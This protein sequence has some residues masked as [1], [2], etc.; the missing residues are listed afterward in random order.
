MLLALPAAVVA[1]APTASSAL[2][3]TGVLVPPMRVIRD[4]VV[5]PNG[6]GEGCHGSGC[7][8]SN[9]NSGKATFRISVATATAVTIE[10]EIRTPNGNDDSFFT[11]FDNNAPQLWHTGIYSYF[12]WRAVR[13]CDVHYHCTPGARSVTLTAGVHEFHVGAREDGAE[14][15]ALRI[16]SGDAIFVDDILG[17]CTDPN[18]WQGNP[19][20]L[21]LTSTAGLSFVDDTPI[22]EP[23]R[24]S[25]SGNRLVSPGL[26]QTSNA[27]G[28]YDGD[29]ALSGCHA[30]YDPQPY[31]DFLAQVTVASNDDDA[32]GFTFGWQSPI[33]HHV[34]FLINDG[35]PYRSY[36]GI[37]GPMIK[38]KRRNQHPCMPT[39][40]RSYSCW[41]PPYAYLRASGAAVAAPVSSSC[42]QTGMDFGNDETCGYATVLE[43]IDNSTSYVPATGYFS[44]P[45]RD[46][47]SLRTAAGC[48][49][50]CFTSR[51]GCD[52]FSFEVEQPQGAPV[53]ICYLKR[54]FSTSSC[55]RLT[56]WVP[57][58]CGGGT[59]QC[60]AGPATCGQQPVGTSPTL[61]APY[62]PHYVRSLQGSPYQLNLLVRGGQARLWF[63]Y[64]NTVVGVRARIPPTTYR[65]GKIGFFT[66]A[67]NGVRFSNLKV[68]D[69]AAGA[70]GPDMSSRLA[71]CGGI[72]SCDTATGLCGAPWAPPPP[73][74]S[75]PPPAPIVRLPPSPSPPPP[76]PILPSP[77]P[78]PLPPSTLIRWLTIQPGVGM[79]GGCVDTYI[80]EAHPYGPSNEALVRFQCDPCCETL[81]SLPLRPLPAYSDPP[82][83]SRCMLLS[84]RGA[85][86][87]VRRLRW[88]SGQ[89]EPRPPPVH[90]TLHAQQ[91]CHSKYDAH[92][93]GGRHRLGQARVYR[94]RRRRSGHAA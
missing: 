58:Q 37:R 13:V 66:S 8:Q 76:T 62:A 10:A 45:R 28:N 86:W 64:A 52:Y 79:D 65:G 2:A 60:S 70:L 77:G 20:E 5:V 94:R 6:I 36:D 89:L 69:L 39:M 27:W 88:L 90:V 38:F 48:Q 43:L 74:P 51:Y 67:E 41:D 12:T 46:L 68:T 75:P 63:Q 72:A 71:Y 29:N 57:R 21:P 82:T 30:L 73:L 26:S 55:N 78:P 33:D 53:A 31:T 14:L 83:P 59:G 56:A 40:N 35:H 50:E 23:C 24:W 85:T 91:R 19:V 54:A 44:G 3:S 11:W 42:I 93:P 80:S 18:P 22:S 87:Q 25:A 16:A 9:T 1:T 7:S 81:L 4:H 84:N 61:P 47:T 32:V 49:Q 34:A 17:V 15:R 92:R